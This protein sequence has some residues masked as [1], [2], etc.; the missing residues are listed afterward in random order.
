MGTVHLLLPK[1]VTSLH[2]CPW[3]LHRAIVTGLAYL[4]LEELPEDEMPDRE[5]WDDNEMMRA[6]KKDV[7][8]LRKEKYGLKSDRDIRDEEIDGPVSHNAAVKE[9]FG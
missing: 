6:W 3:P 5:I 8:R 9:L 4:R 7:E 2:D 1:G